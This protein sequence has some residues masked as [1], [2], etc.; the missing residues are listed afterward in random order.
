MSMRVFIAGGSGLIGRHLAKILL[1]AGHHPVILSR[2]A[3]AVRRDRAMWA[4]PGHPGRSHRRR[5]MARSRSTAATPSSTWPAMAFS[6][7]AGTPRSSARF[8][9]AGSIAPRTSCTA[10]KNAQSRPKVFVQGS[11]DRLLRPAR[12]RRAHRVEPVRQRFSRGRL[13]GMRG[14]VALDRVARSSPG[15]RPDGDRAG[16]GGGRPQDHDADLQA[17]PR[18]ADRQ[19]R[20]A[21]GKGDQWMSWIHIDDIVGIFRLG[22][23]NDGAVRSAERHR[24]RT[25]CATPNSPRRFPACSRS[26]TRPGG[27]ICRSVRPTACSGSCWAKWPPSSRPAKRCLPTKPLPWAISSSIRTLPRPCGPSSRRRPAAPQP[28]AHMRGQP[29]CRGRDH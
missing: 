18:C 21:R 20:R 15:D 29:Q 11:A 22:V 28:A 12:R 3:D 19:R 8:A 23:E 14:C 10:I 6:P 7:N 17:R 25:R 2:H 27:F 1:A 24:P 13:P 5:A 26:R 16:T 9:T 4:L